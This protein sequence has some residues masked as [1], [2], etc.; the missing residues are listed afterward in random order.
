VRET[1][2]FTTAAEELAL[3][4]YLLRSVTVG[5]AKA[6]APGFKMWI[7]YLDTSRSVYGEIAR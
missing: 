2:L 3:E 1:E 7:V 6:Y 5:T 4:E